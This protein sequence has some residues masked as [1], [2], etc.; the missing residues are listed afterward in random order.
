MIEGN[1]YDF[2][3]IKLINL[4]SDGKKYYILKD[5]YNKKYLLPEE[6]YTNYGLKKGNS[7][8]CRLDKINCTGEYFLEPKHPVYKRD[9]LYEFV[10]EKIILSKDINGENLSHVFVK[11]KFFN[12]SDFY[13]FTRELSEEVNSAIKCR[14][15]KIR[16]GSLILKLHGQE[17]NLYNFK[18]GK[19]YKLEITSQK[20]IGGDNQLFILTDDKGKNYSLNS[21]Y[22]K[23]Y[24]LKIGHT[25]KCSVRMSESSGEYVLE[26]ENPHYLVGR[27]YYFELLRIEKSENYFGKSKKLIILKDIFGHEIIIPA[28]AKQIKSDIIGKFLLCEVIA[29]KKGKIFLKSLE[30]I[31]DKP[32]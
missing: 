13:C 18:P 20:T 14:I 26:P 24:D 25:I 19:I 23:H 11:D 22:Y 21:N 31:S 12:K 8:S 9:G 15:E 7:I 1:W 17:N 32:D 6:Y 30:K 29:L 10:I 16:K 27:R 4:P 28:G 3:I 5:L 2:E